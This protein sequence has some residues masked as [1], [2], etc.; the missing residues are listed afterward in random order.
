M[1]RLGARLSDRKWRVGAVALALA[2]IGG[3]TAAIVVL[4][5]GSS[6]GA[7]SSGARESAPRLAGHRF[8]E[9][10]CAPLTGLRWSYPGPAQIGSTTYELFAIHYSCATAASWAKRLARLRIPVFRS[11]KQSTIQGPSG[12]YCT[13]LPDADGH[14]YAGGCQKGE[15]AF[16]W[17]WN[18]ANSRKALVRDETG[19]YRVVELAGSDAQTIIKPL[20]KGHY[21]VYVQNTSGIGFLNGFTWT[22]PPGW[23]IKAIT[24]TTGG[25][26]RL[27]A[28]GTV[29]CK[30]RVA[31]PSCLC[32]ASGGA[33][34]IDLTVSAAQSTKGQTFGVVGAK[35]R[36]TNMTPV[37][38]LIP[39]TPAEAKRQHGV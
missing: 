35:L 38:Y 19:K 14:A 12:F 32:T 11:G 5:G 26:C 3:V 4:V 34:T 10:E 13:A 30:G 9:P 33:V 23:T 37:P 36:I 28:G 18:V 8:L 22:P 31:P 16:G 6:G 25:T 1:V 2:A 27:A 20:A 7:R 39:G 24:K 21:Q 15:T 17:N 29:A